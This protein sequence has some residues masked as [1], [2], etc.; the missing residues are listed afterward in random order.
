MA[1]GSFRQCQCPFR[2]RV[3][4]ITEEE[5]VIL[6][7]GSDDSGVHAAGGYDSGRGVDSHRGG[8]FAPPA[9][10]PHH[11]HPGGLLSF[12]I[13]AEIKNGNDFF[14]LRAQFT[15]EIA[16]HLIQAAADRAEHLN[17]IKQ[18]LSHF[19]RHL[20]MLYCFPSPPSLPP[21]LFLS[22]LSSF[23]LIKPTCPR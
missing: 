8:G 13:G 9:P 15:T 6:S 22:F 1:C 21:S 11:Q 5:C 23:F 14:H 2:G 19:E 3:L 20:G 12:R 17:K 7:L 10:P 4:R 16:F 18:D